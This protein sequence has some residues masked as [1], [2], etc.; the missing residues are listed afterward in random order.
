MFLCIFTYGGGVVAMQYINNWVDVIRD[1][2]FKVHDV[3]FPDDE[4][5]CSEEFEKF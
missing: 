2:Y 3:V 5:L 1:I 4:P